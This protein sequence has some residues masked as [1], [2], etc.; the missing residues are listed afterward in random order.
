MIL[1]GGTMTHRQ[2]ILAAIRGETP[3]RLP[4]A[5]RIDFWQR[6]HHRDGT[7]PAELR[8]LAPHQ[9]ARQL[10]V[11]IYSN[12]PDFSDSPDSVSHRTLGLQKWS[13]SWF[14]IELEDAERVTTSDGRETVVEYHTPAGSI[15]TAWVYTEEMLAAGASVPWITRHAIQHPEDFAVVGHIFSHMRVVP[16]P[17]RYLRWC[18]EVGED[19]LAV[20]YVHSAV[21]P[22]HLI[23]KELMGTEEFFYAMA[24]QP[25]AM[26]RLCEQMKPLFVSLKELALSIPADVAFLGANYDDSITYPAFYRRHLM[27]HLS[28]FAQKLHAQGKF[29]MTHTDGENRRLIPS[30]LETGFD[31]A[32][33]LCPYPM[34]RLHIEEICQAFDG[35]ITI[36]GGIPSVLLCPESAPEAEFRRFIDTLIDQR[37]GRGSFVLGVSD[38]VTADADWNRFLYITEKVS[39]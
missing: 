5:P 11:A 37:R 35:R 8:D 36:W 15:R 17:E 33:S 4:W 20:L 27:P 38:M 22:L 6:A 19:G 1:N 29:L 3:D 16:H 2:R 7:L 21:S 23:M 39:H 9:I 28:D 26:E 14:D 30:Y 18:E 32:D 31:I 10:G 25:Q 24:E 12:I 34:T 13:S